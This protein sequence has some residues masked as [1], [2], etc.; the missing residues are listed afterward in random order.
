MT[1][2]QCAKCG[3]SDR[4]SSGKCRA[5]Q[6][7]R[8][9]K[10][11]I[12]NKEKTRLRNA[13]Y[14]IENKDRM[15]AAS[16]L[17]AKENPERSK[18]IQALWYAE[19]KEQHKANAAAWR[20]INADKIKVRLA[21]WGKVNRGRIN[22]SN[23]AWAERNV[24]KVRAKNKAHRQNNPDLYRIYKQNRRARKLAS[25]GVLSAGLAEKLFR[26]QKGKCACCGLS[27]GENYHLDHIMPLALGGPNTDKN[28]QLLRAKCNH[29]KGSKHPIDFMQSH[30]FLL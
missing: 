17:W 6:K 13:A 5:C 29:K 10:W 26:L 1:V 2:K 21:A 16:A 3:T 8:S 9:A 27:L 15:D 20:R 23:S 14:Y 7:A 30:G 22:A 12:D 28:M 18:A 19:N 25:G 4:N 11:E 24:D